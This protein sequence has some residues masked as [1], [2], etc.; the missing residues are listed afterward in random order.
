MRLDKLIWAVRLHKT[1]SLASKACMTEKVKLNG[2]FAK[3]AKSVEIGN[4]ISIKTNPIWRKFNVLALPKS[5]ISAKLVPQFITETTSENDLRQL[6]QNQLINN[7]NKLLGIKGRPTK[8][9]RRDLGKLGD[10]FSS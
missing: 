7:Q 2:E 8:K 1:R 10:Q 9:D 4:E 3:P 6:A 5:R